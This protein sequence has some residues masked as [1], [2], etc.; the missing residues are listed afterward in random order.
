MGTYTIAMSWNYSE[1]EYM[2]YLHD[3]GT[4]HLKQHDENYL[5]V[6]DALRSKNGVVA[7][8]MERRANHENCSIDYVIANKKLNNIE[9]F[10]AFGRHSYCEF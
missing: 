9:L 3:T 8:I 2:Q 6:G 1:D 7:R 5:K 4:T 10:V